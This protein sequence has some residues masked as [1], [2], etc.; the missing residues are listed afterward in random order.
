[1]KCNFVIGQK[2]T[3]IRDFPE[4]ERMRASSE[5]VDLPRMGV[6]YTIRTMDPGADVWT[7]HKIYLRFE[8]LK[9]GPHINSGIEPNFDS[10]GFRP[11][12]ARKTDISVFKAMLTP[13]GRIPVD[14]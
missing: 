8:E 3:M 9:N 11:V 14:A 10:S 4:K 5:G 12:I 13:A 1:M 2:V 7:K 6:V